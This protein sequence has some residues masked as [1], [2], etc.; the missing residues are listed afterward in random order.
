[1]NKYQSGK[2]YKIIDN[3][4]DMIYVGSTYKTLQQRLKKHEATFKA[5]K[6]GKYHFVT[7]FKIFENNNY[8]IELVEL[9]PCENRKQLELNEGKI[10]KDCRNKKLHIVNK[11]IVG[12]L[13]NEY[14]QNNKNKINTKNI[15]QCSGSYSNRNKIRHEE[16]KKHCEFIKNI[17]TINNTGNIYNIT[18]NVNSVKE[19]E[20]LE[21]EFL[22]AIK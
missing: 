20:Q 12:Q 2:I 21:L 4:S 15:C 16:T 8:K 7:V 3:T 22:N 9:Y 19:L 13:Q 14:Y 17:K 5:F 10:I 11:C 18:I 6:A 1:M